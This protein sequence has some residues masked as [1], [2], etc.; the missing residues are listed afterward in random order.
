MTLSKESRAV[1]LVET[2][3]RLPTANDERLLEAARVLQLNVPPRDASD[4]TL[5]EDSV[6]PE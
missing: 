1:L 2:E 4:R 3:S 6:E 5:A